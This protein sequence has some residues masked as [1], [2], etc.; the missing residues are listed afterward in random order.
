MRANDCG[1][2]VSTSGAKSM[3]NLDEV[4]WPFLSAFGRLRSTISV[5]RLQR[6]CVMRAASE[7][8]RRGLSDEVSSCVSYKDGQ[9]RSTMQ[10]KA[11]EGYTSKNESARDQERFL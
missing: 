3:R 9:R 1:L 5:A 7:G 6:A 2:R 10:G 8:A 4:L 11:K